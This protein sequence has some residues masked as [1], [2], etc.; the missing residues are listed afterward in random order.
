MPPP[1]TAAPR[2]TP[3]ARAPPPRAPPRASASVARNA[4]HSRTAARTGAID[5]YDIG[6]PFVSRPPS[7]DRMLGVAHVRT[8]RQLPEWIAPRY[9]LTCV[10]TGPGN[11]VRRVSCRG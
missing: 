8:S 11:P 3:P 5:L 9:L 10:P 1:A 6:F 2:W 4:E 7:A